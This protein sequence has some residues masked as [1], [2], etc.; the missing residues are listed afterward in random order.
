[1]IPINGFPQYYNWG[2]KT[3]IPQFLSDSTALDADK[4]IAEL[5]FGA[6]PVGPATTANGSTLTAL[7]EAAPDRWLGPSTRFTFGDQLPYL[8]KLIAPDSPLSLQVHPTIAQ[9]QN[10]FLREEAAGLALTDP[11]RTY[12][13][14]N[15]KPEM[16][17]A[18][19]DFVA[20]VGFA[21]RRQARHRLEGLES[22]LATKMSR[23]LLLSTT[24]GMRSIVSWLLDPDSAPSEKQVQDLAA[25]CAA[26]LGR[27]DDP[28]AVIDQIVTQ[29]SQSFPGDPG[30]AVAMLMNPVLLH[31]GEAMFV[32][33]GTL[34]SYQS[35]LALEVMANSDN[36]IRAGLTEKHVDRSGLIEI[37]SFDAH[38]PTRIAPEHPDAQTNHFYAPVEDFELFVTEVKGTPATLGGAGP[39]ILLC[40]DGQ[41]SLE[42]RENKVDLRRGQAVFIS[43]QEGPALLAGDGTVAGCSV[44]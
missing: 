31:P 24:R 41:I 22:A 43:D 19:T 23:R 4:P 14:A 30:I 3:R 44:P 21:V 34:H 12:R 18:L 9:A 42:T 1:M 38:P 20:L 28:F 10:G 25:E 15:H 36:V 39:R 6:H 32:E 37:S 26:R 7:I 11:K 2:S 35:G 29:L 13:D 16:L 33:P 40:I 17:Y 8:V 27:P 5:W